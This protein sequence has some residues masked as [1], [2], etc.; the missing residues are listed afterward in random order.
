MALVWD[1]RDDQAVKL[2]KALAADAVENAG[3]G[4]PGTPI[5]LA[6]AAYL[7]YQRHLRFDPKDPQWLGRDRFVLSAGHAS[8]LQYIQLY[9]AGVGLE[10]EDLKGFRHFGSKTPGHPELGHTE[11]IEVTTGPL[12]SGFAAAVGMAMVARRE[13]GMFDPDTP[14]GES[15]FDH[16][17]YVI[18]GDGCLQEGV[19]SEAASLAGTQ[20]LGNL[21]VIYDDNRI[22]IEDNTSIAFN[23]DVLKRFE[24]YGWHTQKV[25][26]RRA[27]GEYKE[28]VHALND[29]IDNAL[30]EVDRPSI[31]A[32]STIIG[33]PTPGKQD[34]GGIH[35]SKLGGD[36]LTGL[37]QALDLDPE[38]MF[39]M[40]EDILAYTRANADTRARE[41][42]AAWDVAF[43]EWAEAN[44]ERVALLNRIRSGE[45][46]DGFDQ[47]FPH[48]EAGAQIATRAASGKTINA[49]AQVMPEL[50]GGSAD[51]AGSNNT[52]IAGEASFI[53]EHRSSRAFSGNMFGR[54]L[55]FGVREH[56]MGA[57][58]NGIAADRLTRV[59]G[60]T[61]FVFADYMRGAVRLAALMDLPVIYV[62]THDSI[63]VGEDGP[64][65]QPVEHLAAY[66]AIPNLA[67][68]R[69]GD[70]NETAMAW[71]GVLER[72]SPAALILSRQNLPVLPRGGDS[73]ISSAE[74]VLRGAY[75]LMDTD[76]EP[77]VILMGSG[78]E[79]SVALQA[80]EILASEGIGARVVSVPCMEWFAEQDAEYKESVLPAAVEA[81]V[82]IEAGL[83]MP[84]V[85]LVGPKGRSVSIE[86]FGAPGAAETL[87]DNFGLTP[88]AVVDAAKE[89]IQ[90]AN[91]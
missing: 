12:G 62:W 29:A 32:L 40:D 69:P 83:A 34:T 8:L 36:A 72:Q 23:E 88:Q 20:D 47:A 85:A 42:E 87:F 4:H 25:D 57:V 35:G 1:E 13:H 73:G 79:V 60:G 33:W 50:W 70:A 63:G 22:S 31:I 7:I 51:L 82:S 45:L 91:D 76:G 15:P 19:A 52:L 90:L 46:P 56:A 80:A 44:P 61:F 49:V 37:K 48:F 3:S 26:W 16:N 59:Y 17:V 10:M 41:A 68:V 55:H 81:R 74:G 11:G 89:S 27:G 77:D 39:Q 24:A 28:D 53:P 58:M 65:H 71:K 54:N 75:T 43:R 14:L 6:A 84:W 9:Y 38:T 66:R 78:S 18:V 21:V 30:A 5:S 67:L 86:T 2:A 64:T